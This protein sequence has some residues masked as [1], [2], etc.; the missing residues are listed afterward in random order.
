MTLCNYWIVKVDIPVHPAT[1]WFVL[2]VAAATKAVVLPRNTN[3]AH[4]II[5]LS[6]FERDAA[7]NAIWP[8]FGNLNTRWTLLVNLFT[9]LNAAYSITE[10]TRRAGAYGTN[11]L[12][13][14]CTTWGNKR[15]LTHMEY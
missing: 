12:V 3:I 8:I 7:S 4:L 14:P 10:S 9:G 13:H 2:G 11:N 1:K 15:L 6:I 5:P